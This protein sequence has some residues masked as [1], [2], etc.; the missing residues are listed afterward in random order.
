MLGMARKKR[1]GRPPKPPGQVRNQVVY[2]AMTKAERKVLEAEAKRRQITV[3]ELLMEP[4]RKRE[5]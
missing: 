3:S 5:E 1:M 2:V 4:R